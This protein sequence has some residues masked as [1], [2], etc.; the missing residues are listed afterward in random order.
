MWNYR[1]KNTTYT[2]KCSTYSLFL[3]H[4]VFTRDATIRLMDQTRLLLEHADRSTNIALHV[5]LH[6]LL[7]LWTEPWPGPRVLA[8][9]QSGSFSTP[10][11]LRNRPTKKSTYLDVSTVS[12]YLSIAPAAHLTPKCDM[13]RF[14]FEIIQETK[15]REGDL[16]NFPKHKGKYGA[17]GKNTKGVS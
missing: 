5:Y 9:G 2:R 14:S 8:A 7:T 12:T 15:I 11:L 16:T 6:I 4:Q 1:P 13:K 3:F 10:F 17:V